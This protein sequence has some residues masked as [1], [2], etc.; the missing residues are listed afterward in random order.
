[1]EPTP[2]F[3][4][5]LYFDQ[6]DEIDKHLQALEKIIMKALNNNPSTFE[7]N[8][9]Y[10][11]NSFEQVYELIPKQVQLFSLGGQAAKK[12]CEIGVNAGHSLLLFLLGRRALGL[13]DK[14]VDCYLFDINEHPYTEP[15]IAYL[16]EQFP[17]ANIKF[18]EGD[19]TVELPTFLA[20]RG[21]ELGGTFDI[22][23]V[24]GGHS[25]QCMK[26]DMACAQ[27]LV[28]PGGYVIVDDTNDP[29]IDGYVEAALHST[30]R[31]KEIQ[32]YAQLPM[33]PHRILQK[34]C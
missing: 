31:Y 6:K 28:R 12:L 21:K 25:E 29:M 20:C 14:P 17:E 33:Y 34:A 2:F 32:P 22:V 8:A 16:R 24:D 7:G 15:A 27:K 4:E 1:M 3:A 9:F 19:S 26:S 13:A 30:G 11:H 5:H 10:R 23:H 18:F